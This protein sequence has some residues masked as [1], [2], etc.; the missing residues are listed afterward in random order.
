MDIE[1]LVGEKE[2]KG[3]ERRANRYVDEQQRDRDCQVHQ[4]LAPMVIGIRG[5]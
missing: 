4:S 2:H 5:R 1:L 3:A